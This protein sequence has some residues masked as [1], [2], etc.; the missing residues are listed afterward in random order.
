MGR[1]GLF[2]R[3]VYMNVT[4]DNNCIIALENNET[5]ASS[6][7]E[8]VMMHNAGKI[9]L[10]LATISAS[11]RQRGGIYASNYTAFQE[12][13]IWLGL[14]HLATLQHPGH[15]G[16]S[17]YGQ[18]SYG[19]NITED[20]ERKLHAILFP[21]KAFEHTT[22]PRKHDVEPNSSEIDKKWRNARCDV[23]ALRSHIHFG[24]G[25]FVTADHNFLADTKKPLLIALG[26]GDILT[27]QQAVIKLRAI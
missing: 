27:P 23:L 4:L 2:I 9:N 24:G 10:R 5:D 14:G 3:W 11:E 26:A 25:I 17:Y 12:K 20:L 18:A 8:L 1:I 7:K 15:Y 22:F 19:D 21:W 13:I 6:I 16:V